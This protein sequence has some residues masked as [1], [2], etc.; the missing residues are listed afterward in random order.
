MKKIFDHAFNGVAITIGVAFVL[1]IAA[2][3]IIE[4][5]HDDSYFWE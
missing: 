4:E 5:N 2:V 3:K 1:L